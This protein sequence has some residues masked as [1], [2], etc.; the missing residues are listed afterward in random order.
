MTY[1]YRKIGEVD[2]LSCGFR[3]KYRLKI[4]Y[5]DTI[6]LYDLVEVIRGGPRG[7]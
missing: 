7:I 1:N 4:V 3:C 6:N 2:L 5:G